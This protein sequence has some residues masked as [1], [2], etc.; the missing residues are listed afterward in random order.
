M[1]RILVTGAAGFLGRNITHYLKDKYDLVLVDQ[2][3]G[4]WTNFQLEPLDPNIEIAKADLYNDLF[5]YAALLDK[6][7]VVIHCA[8]RARIDPSWLEYQSYYKTNI[9]DTHKFFQLCQ[10]YNIKKFIYIS[11]S[12]VYGNNGQEAQTEDGALNP[13]SPYAVS[14]LAAEWALRVQSQKA[15]ITEL[16]IVRPFTMYGAYMDYGDRALMIPRYMK[17][18]VDDQPLFIHGDGDQRRDFVHA[19]DAVQALELIIEKGMRDEIYNIGSGTSTSVKE[20]ADV[21]SNKQ[22]KVPDRIGQV[23]LTFADITKLKQLGYEPKVNVINWI[24]NQVEQFKKRKKNE[25][26]TSSS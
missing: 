2:D 18:L 1:K 13:S 9:A 23:R 14:K 4:E 7:D 12:S 10:E 8:N 21:V 5:V 17:A 3:P 11:S 19:S 15:W 26:S 16:I 20:I 6:V 22:V 24:G 25:S